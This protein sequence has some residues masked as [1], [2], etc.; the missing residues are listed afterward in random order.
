MP[1]AGIPQMG[2]RHR[3]GIGLHSVEN[4]ARETVEKLLGGRREF[5]GMNQIEWL[6]RF[7]AFDRFQRAGKARQRI[8]AGCRCVHGL[9]F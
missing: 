3:M 7:Q 1:D 5:V 9:A 6:G 2:Q 8:E 4:I